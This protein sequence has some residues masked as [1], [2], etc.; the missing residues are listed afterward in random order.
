MI[1]RVFARQKDAPAVERCLNCGGQT[2]GNR[3]E[4]CGLDSDAASLLLRR[5][6]LMRTGIFLL[7]TLAFLA[8]AYRYPPL[9]LDGMLI[10]AGLVFFAA[11]ALAVW[12]ERGALGGGQVEVAKRV[13]LGLVPVPWL[14]A[15]LL[16]VNA[17]FDRAPTRGCPTTVVGKFAM[18]A[19]MP[20]RQLVVY[21]CREGTQYER[22]AVNREDYY[23]F[24]VGDHVVVRVHEGLAGI[25]WVAG[26][27]RN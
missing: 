8:V 5:R 18:A 9:E 13:F 3:C 23:R 20:S 7:G 21:S 19:M 17:S 11:L 15:G 27:D 12:V 26:V 14:L 10:F 24:A 4:A 22:V 6:L 1:P 2:A 25:P 16:W